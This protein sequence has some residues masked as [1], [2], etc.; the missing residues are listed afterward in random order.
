MTT[1]NATFIRLAVGTALA[2]TAL[3]GCSGQVAPSAAHSVG[4]AETALAKGKVDK[5]IT[6]AEAAVLA[7]PRDPY[8]R[9]LLGNAYLENG[10]LA[11]AAQS[12]QD[13]IDLGDTSP[14][15]AVSLSLALTGMGDRAAAIHALEKHEAAIDP[16]DFGLA[17]ALAGQP[18]RGVSV[19]SNTL[20]AG[21]NTAKVR[22][23]LAYA[24]AMSGQWREARLMVAEDV[25]A[26]MVGERMAEWGAI[27]HPEQFRTRIASLLGVDIVADPG[28]PQML[29]LGNNPSVDMLA[30]E[31]VSAEEPQVEL[32]AGEEL[33]A[34]TPTAP[35]ERLALDDN[36]LDRGA[37]AIAPAP[38]ATPAER[39]PAPARIAAAKPVETVQPAAPAATPAPRKA[40]ASS[41]RL[42]LASGD[43][44]IQLGSY[45]SMADAEEGWSKFQT[46][47]PELADA[48]RVI[49]KARVNGKLYFRVAAVGYAKDSARAL[50][51]NVKG[52][53][54]S[55]IA[56]SQSNPLPGAIANGKIRVAAR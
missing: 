24:Y 36:F 40:N 4:K 53:G 5:A 25:P 29:A 31:T 52:K 23:N 34:V 43:Y 42:T 39:K 32:A 9:T 16:A 18:Q 26:D 30:A 19:L 47:Y 41:P 33:P 54:G 3:A 1:R 6:H 48:E 13:A 7:S 49:S 37:A 11:S 45:F 15:T 14:R 27:A 12:F 35:I 44:N 22:Q 46:M 10:R 38:A 17:I 21:N 20:R 2:S 56:Y 55:C 51:S 50:C 8:A 28:Q